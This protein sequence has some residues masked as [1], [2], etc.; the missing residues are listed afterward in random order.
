MIVLFDLIA[1]FECNL[2]SIF[3]RE[4]SK[5]SINWLIS[6]EYWDKLAHILYESN[7]SQ[8]IVTKMINNYCKSFVDEEHPQDPEG[9]PLSNWTS[10]CESKY[11]YIIHVYLKDNTAK[12]NMPLHLKWQTCNTASWLFHNDSEFNVSN[13][14]L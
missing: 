3:F 6:K 12:T 13:T 11:M 9:F 7:I 4:N 8:V 10:S 14:I 2:I 5:K 1:L